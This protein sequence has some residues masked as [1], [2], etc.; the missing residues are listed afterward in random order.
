MVNLKL[1][2]LRQNFLEVQREATSIETLF[3]A[4]LAEAKKARPAELQDLA[5]SHSIEDSKRLYDKV[6]DRLTEVDL[7]SNFGGFDVQVITPPTEAEKVSP[8]AYIVFPLAAVL[9]AFLGLGLVFLA[10][11]TDRTFR[12]PEDIR[13]RLGLPVLGVIPLLKSAGRRRP[14][15]WKAVSCWTGACMPGPGPSRRRRNLTAAC[16][17]PSTSVRAGRVPR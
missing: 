8:K 11:H 10:E 16:E 5:M 4:E 13:R 1:G 2:Q 9:G 14:L 17:P 3:N 15:P 12:S 7:I 6:I